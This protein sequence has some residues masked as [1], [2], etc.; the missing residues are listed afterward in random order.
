MLVEGR[1]EGGGKIVIIVQKQC[2]N[3]LFN[4]IYLLLSQLVLSTGVISLMS[5]QL[6]TWPLPLQT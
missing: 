4:L 3:T 1:E 5:T 2:C 6:P